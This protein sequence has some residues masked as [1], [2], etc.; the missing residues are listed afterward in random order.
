MR[1]RLVVALAVVALA[2]CQ[3]TSGERA[4]K[5]EA[6]PKE[7]LSK[8]AGHGGM[9][10]PQDV[11]WKEGPPTLPPGAKLAVLEGDPSKPGPFTMRFQ[12]PAGYKIPPHWHPSLEHVTVLSGMWH[13]GM[14][15]T[16][17][18]KVARRLP[19]GSFA[20]L[21]GKTNHFAFATE[22]SVVQTHGAG[23]WGIN[24][25]NPTDDPRNRR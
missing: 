21:P 8:T 6:Q 17:D 15:D 24:Y 22:E 10:T 25:L 11:G 1:W 4:P 12:F 20:F 7:A 16:F 23:P 5:Q 19:G 18:E 2:G 9:F 3:S 14:G 13:I